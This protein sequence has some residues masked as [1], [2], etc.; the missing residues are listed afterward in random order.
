MI[1]IHVAI[2]TKSP[3]YVDTIDSLKGAVVAEQVEVN[4]I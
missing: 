4:S 3:V 2:D 1:R